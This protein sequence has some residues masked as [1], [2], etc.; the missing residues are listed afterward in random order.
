MRHSSEK[1]LQI[2]CTPFLEGELKSNDGRSPGFSVIDGITVAGQRP[3]STDF[4]FSPRLY[5]G[6]P[7]LIYKE[8]VRCTKILYQSGDVK[9]FLTKNIFHHQNF[10][11]V[12]EFENEKAGYPPG[13]NSRFSDQ[14]R[15]NKYQNGKSNER[16]EK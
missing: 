11:R 15:M 3:T 8:Q 4:P 2:F 16:Q 12:K 14:R 13:K 7:A 10:T 1:H 5:F 6:A 9:L